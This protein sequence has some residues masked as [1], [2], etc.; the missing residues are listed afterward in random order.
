MET[1]TQEDKFYEV[2]IR[3]RFMVKDPDAL[4]SDIAFQDVIPDEECYEVTSWTTEDTVTEVVEGK[5]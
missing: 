1:N 2:N 5:Q 3:V 4:P